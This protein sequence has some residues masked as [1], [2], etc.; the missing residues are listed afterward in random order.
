MLFLLPPRSLLSEFLT[1][2]VGG[3]SQGRVAFYD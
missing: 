1:G 3:I 2:G